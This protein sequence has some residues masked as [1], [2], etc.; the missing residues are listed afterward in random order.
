MHNINKI[1]LAMVFGLAFSAHGQE[2]TTEQADTS[3]QTEATED[4]LGLEVISV[5]ATKR[6]TKLMERRWQSRHSVRRN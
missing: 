3:A 1:T 4:E 2:A 6:K 5:T